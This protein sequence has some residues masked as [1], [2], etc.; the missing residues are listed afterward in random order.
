MSDNKT[1]SKTAIVGISIGITLLTIGLGVSN[2]SDRNKNKD[3]VHSNKDVQAVNKIEETSDKEGWTEF[4]TES[5]GDEVYEVESK[6]KVVNVSHYVKVVN[7]E[8]DVQ[9]ISFVKG[10]IDGL[11]GLYEIEIPYE[12]SI[13]LKR[14][15]EFKIKYFYYLKNGVKVIYSI[16]Y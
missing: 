8:K 13:L 14:E 2:L 10:N 4:K 16:S 6:F 9:I 5:I 11:N 3:N 7:K 15:Q 12:K 1:V